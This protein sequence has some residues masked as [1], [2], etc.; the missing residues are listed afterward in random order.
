MSLA[1]ACMIA[2]LVTAGLPTAQA[3]QSK[4]TDAIEDAA[5]QKPQTAPMTP[6]VPPSADDTPTLQPRSPTGEL[7][8][9]PPSGVVPAPATGDEHMEKPAP[10]TGPNSMPTVPNTGTAPKPAPSTTPP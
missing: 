9:I 5:K 6:G 7:K 4:G 8:R 1:L 10:P 3:A 2:G